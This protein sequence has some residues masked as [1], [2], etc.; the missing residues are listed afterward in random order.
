MV[1]P[2]VL[3]LGTFHMADDML[4]PHRQHEIKAC[5]NMLKRY[6]PTKVAVEVIT[7]KDELL[8]EEYKK[9][10]SNDF[11]LDSKW[12][13]DL[14][15]RSSNEVYQLGF[16]IAEESGHTKIFATDWME[17]IGNRDLGTVMEW[18]EQNQLALSE[19]IKSW[20]TKWNWRDSSTITITE[21]LKDMN[22]PEFNL[23]DHQIYIRLIARIGEAQ[24]YVGIDWMRWWYQRNLIIYSNI[25]RLATSSDD[26][27]L[28]IYGH[29][30]N[31]LINQFLRESDL[32]EVEAPNLYLT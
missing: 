20:F 13:H 11:G 21:M 8:N 3:I 9:Y 6:K 17:D 27:I 7:A 26:R 22:N 14:G 28:V 29:G 12:T 1:K 32:F 30:H 15:Y 16:R 31:H 4:E 2:S 19:D 5:V 18:A 25:A 23:Y 10:V 24:D